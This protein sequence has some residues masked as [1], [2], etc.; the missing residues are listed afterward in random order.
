MVALCFVLVLGS[1]SPCLSPLS[2]LS[3]SSSDSHPGAPSPSADLYTTSQ[4]T[5]SSPDVMPSFQS[6]LRLDL[7]KRLE[8]E[9][10]RKTKQK[11]APS[12]VCSALPQPALLRRTGSS[13]GEFNAAVTSGGSAAL[14]G[15]TPRAHAPAR[16]QQHR[17]GAK[18]RAA[19]RPWISVTRW[20]TL[21]C[22]LSSSG[23]QAES[24]SSSDICRPSP[25]TPP[26]NVNPLDRRQSSVSP[27][28]RVSFRGHSVL[29]S[30]QPKIRRGR[31]TSKDSPIECMDGL[32]VVMS[33]P[34][35][36][37]AHLTNII[38]KRSEHSQRGQN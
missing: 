28:E 14:R 18:V 36:F 5:S 32:N 33:L 27:S 16:H 35:S 30:F 12:S 38:K 4:G 17:G 15:P 11:T 3:H 29:I 20:R 2:L 23:N 31:S 26:P 21:T 9:P 24:P 13:R 34:G 7:S 37:W 25:L 1:F 22:Y 6:A 10:S 19:P 8:I